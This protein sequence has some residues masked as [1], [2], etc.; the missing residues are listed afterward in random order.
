MP[1]LLQTLTVYPSII[2]HGVYGFQ[3]FLIVFQSVQCSLLV[4]SINVIQILIYTINGKTLAK[5][6]WI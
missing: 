3:I 5:F 4:V 6:I 1:Y 2:P